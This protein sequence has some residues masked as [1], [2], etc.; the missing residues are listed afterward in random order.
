ML[1]KQSNTWIIFEAFFFRDHGKIDSVFPVKLRF[2]NKNSIK[3]S[4]SKLTIF[5]AV[6]IYS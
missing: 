3:N 6:F 4:L 5:Y 1:Q 2:E